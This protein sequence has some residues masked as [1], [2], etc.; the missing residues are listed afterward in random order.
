MW[1]QTT[2][3]QRRLQAETAQMRR[4]TSFLLNQDD[5]NGKLAWKGHLGGHD[6]LLEYSDEHPDKKM[7][8]YVTNPQ[9]PCVN[10]HIHPDGTICYMKDQEWSP[11]WTAYTVYLTAIRFLDDF[12]RGR[13]T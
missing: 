9:L 6:I 11:D 8:A 2:Q 13:M 3:G 12:H 4:N 7:I 10:L 1:Y 5:E